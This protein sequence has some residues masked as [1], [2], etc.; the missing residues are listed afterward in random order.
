MEQYTWRYQ[1]NGLVQLL[2]EGKPVLTAYAAAKN[3]AGHQITSTQ[4]KL[5]EQKYGEDSSLILT[6]LGKNNMV[7]T[8]ILTVTEAGVPV[9]SCVL[10]DRKGTEVA[11]N[12]LMPLGVFAGN[13]V[14]L[15][16][17]NS[18]WSQMVQV[19]YDN[20]MWLRYEAVPLRSGR[21]S[22]DYTALIGPDRREGLLLGSLDFDTWKNAVVC[23]PRDARHM[24]VV[25]GEADEGTHD[26]MPHGVV[27]GKQV[28]SSRFCV[29]YGKDYRKLME[30]YGDLVSAESVP[31]QWDMG[32]PFGFNSWSG[33]GKDIGADTFLNASDV[34]RN[35]LLTGGYENKGVQYINYDAG[36]QKISPKNRTDLMANL[37][38]RGQRS[39][40]YDAPFA[41]FGQDIH[42]EIPDMPGHC[43][44]E[45]L[46]KDSFGDPLPRVDGAIPFD[47]THPLW[48]RYTENKVRDYALSGY[49]YVKLDF[50]THGG[51]EGVRHNQNIQ[52]G[53]QAIS[54]AYEFLRRLYTPE[55]MGRPF[56]VSLSI[57]PLFPNRFGHARRFSCD[58]FGL[59]ED[60][61]YVLNAQT[62]AW[63]Q[64]GRVYAFN[65]A[66]HISLYKGVFAS[67]PSMMGEARAR[68]TTAV[69][70]GGVMMLSDPFEIPE[71][72]E[73]VEQIA[74]NS[75]INA[76][77]K[78]GVSFFPDSGNGCYGSKIFSASIE[79]KRYIAWFSSSVDPKRK[80]LDLKDLGMEEVPMFRDLWTGKTFCN[81]DGKL[82]WECSVCDAVLLEEIR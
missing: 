61:E 55:R 57:S 72:R 2:L 39:G 75:R 8:Q 18:L 46:L 71:A 48:R 29:L 68:Y 10:S 6:Y 22:Y 31:M 44:E 1:G 11:S 58:A 36:W 43:F 38:G 7:L 66:D 56:F 15:E 76:V 54:S 35:S 23:S 82:I 26:S 25:C 40:I 45:I 5:V 67:R 21:K 3:E 32:T 70:S 53:R 16:L 47:V 73:R 42:Q 14:D 9:A 79:E 19:P 30:R 69:I 27:R 50:L 62:W 24:L 74:T 51:M 34:L 60:V 12:Y 81:Q 20:T 59:E 80:I 78:S 63:W 17:W 33:Y 41:F 4:A 52:T 64:N 13:G 49:D 37:R 77:A 65:D 28:R